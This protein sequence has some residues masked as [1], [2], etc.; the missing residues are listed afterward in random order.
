MLFPDGAGLLFRYQAP[1]ESMWICWMAVFGKKFSDVIRLN[2]LEAS[3]SSAVERWK[4]STS[5]KRPVKNEENR[6]SHDQ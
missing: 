1:E 2:C 4:R 6:S 5:A 3:L